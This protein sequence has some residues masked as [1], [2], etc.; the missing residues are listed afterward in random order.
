MCKTTVALGLTVIVLLGAMTPF[1]ASPFL[2]NAY[3]NSVSQIATR[4]RPADIVFVGDSLTAGGEWN[5]AFGLFSVIN[6]ATNG[7][8]IRQIARQVDVAEHYR[9]RVIAALAGTNDVL[10]GRE[11]DD[12]IIADYKSMIGHMHAKV[13]VVTLIPYTTIPDANQRIESVNYMIGN[14]ARS[15]GIHVVD[16]NPDVAPTGTLLPQYTI[17]GV[18]LSAEAHRIW[19]S[20]LRSSL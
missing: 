2:R 4:L 5:Q 9:P 19:Q 1:A 7:S 20:K 18:H 11:S 15:S 16:I 13:L 17:D 8:F 10:D 12:A 3:L 14:L 6:L